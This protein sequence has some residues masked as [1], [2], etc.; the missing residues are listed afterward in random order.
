MLS[1]QMHDND[2]LTS[3]GAEKPSIFDVLGEESLMLGLKPAA[4]FLVK[5]IF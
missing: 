2:S 4:K 3:V 1:S 5:V